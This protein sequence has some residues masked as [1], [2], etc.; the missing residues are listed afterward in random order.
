MTELSIILTDM[1]TKRENVLPDYRLLLLA[2]AFLLLLYLLLPILAPFLIAAIL[3]YICNPLVGRLGNLNFGKVALGRT[4]GTLI[5]MLLLIGIIITIFLIVLPLLQKELLLVAERLPGYFDA[6]RN[7]LD[8]WL[9][10]HFGVTLAVDAAQVQEIITKNWKSTSSFIGQLLVSVGNHGLTLITWI[11]SLLLVPI[12]LFYL[13]RDWNGVIVRIAQ[14][15][16]RRWYAKTAIIAKEIDLV[17][18][19]FLRGQL[20]VMLLMSAFYAAG[21]LL[22]GLELAVPI[23]L[24]AGLLGFV[25][26]LGITT[27]IV[28]ALLAGALQFTSF[29]QL[30]PVLVVFGAGQVLEGFLLTPWLVGNRIGLH[31]V[32]VIFA[33]LAGGQLFGFAGVLLA[34]P[35]SATIAVGLKHAKQGYLASHLYLK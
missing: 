34:L 27:G 13:L 1:V 18:A 6:L 35:V 15:L 11:I 3:A 32:V 9:L 14:L 33:L 24:I 31:P 16:P 28:L 2:A 19:E 20:S 4:M 5:V 29:G 22:T 12:V 30:I 8:P 23:S 21:L 25:P 26:Y 17:L 7:H 10:K